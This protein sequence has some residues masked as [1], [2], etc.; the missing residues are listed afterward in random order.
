MV[1]HPP[2]P[3]P[4]DYRRMPFPGSVGL[5]VEIVE[6]GA[7]PQ[8]LRIVDEELTLVDV[9]GH[10]VR[11]VGLELQ[12]VRPRGGGS[13]HDFQRPVEGPVVI[14]RHLGDDEGWKA[15]TDL[16]PPDG[17][18]VQS[19][20]PLPKHASSRSFFRR[21]QSSRKRAKETTSS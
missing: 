11:G 10:R 21:S 3:A 7:L 6:G 13:L 4:F 5:P 18:R 14:P 12:G 2:P 15:G 16:S 20:S 8:A 19:A 9:Q 17:Y 1:R